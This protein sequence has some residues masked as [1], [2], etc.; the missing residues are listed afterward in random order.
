MN[1]YTVYDSKAEA[2]LQPFYSRTAGEAIRNFET[3]CN[4]SEH[5]F[6]IHA[7]DYTL[8]EIGEFNE[9]TG[10]IQRRQS[11]LNLGNALQYIRSAQLSVVSS[12]ATNPHAEEPTPIN[13]T[14][15]K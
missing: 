5:E 9:T 14:N 6:H 4:K 10:F 7:A 15:T 3:A 13:N 2:Y 1:I 12:E 11:H 8:F